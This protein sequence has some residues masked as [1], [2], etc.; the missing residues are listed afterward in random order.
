VGR[1]DLGYRSTYALAGL[2][3]SG[4]RVAKRSP[5][6]NSKPIMLCVRDCDRSLNNYDETRPSIGMLRPYE[7]DRTR[8]TLANSAGR[9]L[10]EQRLE[11]LNG[12]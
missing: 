10:E 8:M 12:A 6:D 11:M 9:V 5:V 3:Q 1:E 4:G 2:S 7:G